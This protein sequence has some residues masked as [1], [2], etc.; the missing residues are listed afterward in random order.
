L[1]DDL[2]TL[3]SFGPD[4]SPF[5]TL[6][7]ASDLLPPILCDHPTLLAFAVFHGALRCFTSLISR[8]TLWFSC[9]DGHGRNLLHFAAASKNFALFN[10]ISHSVKTILEPDAD[11]LQPV[12]YAAMFGNLPV[13]RFLWLINVPFNQITPFGTVVH[14]AVANSRLETLEWLIARGQ[15]AAESNPDGLTPL[16]FV[17]NDQNT[18]KIVDLLVRNGASLAIH[19]D[20]SILEHYIGDN[21]ER[22]VKLLIE[23]GADPLAIGPS[24]MNAIQF[25]KVSNKGR[26]QQAIEQ[27]V[28][29]KIKEG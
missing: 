24:Q 27:T 13:L 6:S 21:N 5:S 18:E 29:T 11:G 22:I 26:I 1:H 14:L 20:E 4:L 2:P 8:S 15:S 7:L 16:Y 19:R 9:P 25:A 3:L 17:K 28:K 23:K 10:I 12:H